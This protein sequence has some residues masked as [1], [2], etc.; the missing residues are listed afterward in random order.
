MRDAREPVRV[1][2]ADDHQVV[3]EGLRRLLESDPGIRVIGEAGSGNEALALA[4][5]Q[6]PDILILDI[7][8]PGKSGFETLRELDDF[9]AVRTV[10]FTAAIDRAG[11]FNAVQLGARG[12]VLKTSARR[13]PSSIAMW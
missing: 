12:V 11:I 8:M 6:K 2:I 9:G 4:A 7:S 13:P 1:L 5:S 10:V 3:R